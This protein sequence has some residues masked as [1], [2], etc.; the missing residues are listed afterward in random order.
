METKKRGCCT[1]YKTNWTR[2]SL[3]EI[4]GYYWQTWGVCWSSEEHEER[5]AVFHNKMGGWRCREGEIQED[6]SS[7]ANV[8][9]EHVVLEFIKQY[10]IW[11][12]TRL[13]LTRI[14]YFVAL[15]LISCICICIDWKPGYRSRRTTCF[16]LWFTY[17]SVK[18]N[19][20]SESH[21][22]SA[23]LISL[24]KMCSLNGS[25]TQIW[26]IYSPDL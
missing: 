1:G 2:K 3:L 16:T 4:M 9:H 17:C 24:T 6:G 19:C 26:R 14:S 5:A 15:F 8:E 12:F 22:F 18:N 11:C 10:K 25:K 13:F 7:A 23:L 21:S 20:S